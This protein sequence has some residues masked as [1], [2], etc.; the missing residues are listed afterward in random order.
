MAWRP[1][2]A[3]LRTWRSRRRPLCKRGAAVPL[4]RASVCADASCTCPLL[5][6]PLVPPP[7]S[8]SPLQG[9]EMA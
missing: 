5:P 4:S 7:C 6:L 9:A 1:K 8:A 2:C 3:C